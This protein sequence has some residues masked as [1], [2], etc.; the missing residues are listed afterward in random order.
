MSFIAQSLIRW[1]PL[2]GRHDLPWQRSRDAYAIWLSEIMLQQTQVSTVIPYYV[3]FMQTFPAIDSLA[4]A[5]LDD[6]LTLWSGL[7][8]YSRA[9]NLHLTAQRIVHEHH[10]RFPESRETIQQLP[11]IGR[12][13]AAAI[14]VFAFGQREAILDGNVKRIFARFFG[15]E[16]YPGQPKIQNLLWQ[17][18]ELSLPADHRG[19]NIETYTQAL[20]DL[21]AVICTRD[22]PQCG[23]CPL[24]PQCIAWQQ[25]RTTQL[26]TAKPRKPLPRKET[27]LLLLQYQQRLLLKKRPAPGIW[28]GLW[29]PPEMEIG[30]DVMDYCHRQ[31]GFAVR[32]PVELP[33]FDHQ[34]THFKLRIHPQ[35]LHVVSDNSITSP[36]YVWLKPAE[37]I[38]QGI[39]AP[40][41]ALLKRN[42]LQNYTP[43]SSLIEQ[44]G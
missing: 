33:A 11:G 38:V 24:Q 21:G 14:A 10:G 3:R 8:Y 22:K 27:V 9:R 20:M 39:P 13:T 25:Q 43:S 26:P 31:W 16:G 34:F 36:D 4:Q 37:A 23:I 5:H 19:D 41:R 29:C 28:G 40:V 15:I 6:V 35:L 18:A 32:P 42:F 1:H 17:K 30:A 2:H 12:S 7:G 44:Y